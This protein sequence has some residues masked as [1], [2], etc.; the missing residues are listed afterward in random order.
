M[1]DRGGYFPVPNRLLTESQEGAHPV[2]LAV[3]M[4]LA[5]APRVWRARGDLEPFQVEASRAALADATGRSPKQVRTA[6][7]WLQRRGFVVRLDTRPK[8]CARYQLVRGSA[9]AEG[10]DGGQE[11]AKRRAKHKPLSGLALRGLRAHDGGQGRAKG[12]PS[13]HERSKNIPPPTPPADVV[14]LWWEAWAGQPPVEAH[15]V[16]PDAYRLTVL[17]R[18]TAGET[19]DDIAR[20]FRSWVAATDPDWGHRKGDGVAEF[21]AVAAR[22]IKARNV[23]REHRA[24]WSARTVSA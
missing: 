16:N 8:A 18:A 15:A 20:M 14:R 7:A 24:R 5:S 6:L 22:W 21:A 11:R 2:A 17:A 4:A 9:P 23:E 13:I 12:G 10:Q 1:V 3:Y 19:A